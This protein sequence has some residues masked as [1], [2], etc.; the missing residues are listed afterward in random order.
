MIQPW[1]K[2]KNYYLPTC[3]PTVRQLRHQS[4][5]LRNHGQFSLLV[6]VMTADSSS[7]PTLSGPGI[8]FAMSKIID[9]SALSI[10]TFHTWYKNVHIP[11]VLATGCVSS[12][13]RF[14]TLDPDAEYPYLVIYKVSDLGVLQSDAFKAIPHAH[15][16]LPGGKSI[17]EFVKFRHPFYKLTQ[18]FEPNKGPEGKRT[19]RTVLVI[20]TPPLAQSI[21]FISQLTS[22]Q[23]SARILL[24]HRLRRHGT[25]RRR[26]RR[27]GCL[28]PRGAPGPSHDAARMETEHALHAHSGRQELAGSGCG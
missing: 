1:H 27:P 25:R 20:L 13:T 4:E 6:V 12:A 9:P 16:S 7:P 28:V 15:E 24:R 2:N 22:H 26:P 21:S 23:K 14:K 8:I 5:N 3:L 19:D 18:T 11:D 10:D 17:Y